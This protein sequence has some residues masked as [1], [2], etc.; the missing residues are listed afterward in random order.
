M[1]CNKC[2]KKPVYKNGLCKE[3]YKK[4]SRKKSIKQKDLDDPDY[5]IKHLDKDEK[6]IE[7][8]QVSNIMYACIV[9]LFAISI[10][11][12][13]KTLVEFFWLRNNFYFPILVATIAICFIGIYSAVYFF[14]RK[15]YLTS[16]RIIGKWGIFNVKIINAPLSKIESIDTF[17]IKAVEICIYGN[18]YVFDFIASPEKFKL[19]T[20]KQIKSIIDSTNDEKVL[21]SFSHSLNDKLEEY[22]LNEEYPNMT[23]CKCCGEMISKE[24][25]FCVHCGQPLHENEREADWILKI[26]CFLIP[27]LGLLIYLLNIG[28]H[29]KLSN[30]SLMF[31]IFGLFVFITIY[32][33]VASVLSVL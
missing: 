29:P 2:G 10:V 13:P 18:S 4:A 6:I 33:S 30:Q 7:K 21:L 17:K 25:K 27:P 19:D 3:C 15:I 14:S 9:F 26:L 23:Y 31:S 12:F 1:K 11:L 22:K 16:K 28:E 24:S 20:I 32:L 8:M 5:I